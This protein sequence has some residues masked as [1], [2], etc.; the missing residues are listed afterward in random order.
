MKFLPAQ[1]T[2]ILQRGPRQRNVRLLIRFVMVLLGLMT[3]YSV[4]FHVLM[5]ME[6]QHHSW[7]S[8]FYWVLVVMSTLGFGD[9]T[10]HT[11]IGR[12]F[13][14]LVVISGL[15]FLLVLMPFT[16]IEFFYAPWMEAQAAKRAPRKLPEDTS[17]HVLITSLDPVTSV[18]MHRLTQYGH[19]YTLIVSNPEDAVRL[20][21]AGVSVMVGDPDDPET[22]RNARVDKASL[23]VATGTDVANTNIAFTTRQIS[24]KPLIVATAKEL[25]SVEIL[26]MAGANKV[27]RLDEMLGQF[28][29]RRTDG[30]PQ[31]AHVVGEFGPVLI[32]EATAGGTN[33]VG[34]T[35]KEC[36]LTER[37]RVTVVGGWDRGVFRMAS[38]DMQITSSLVLLLAGSK[39]QIDQFNQI[40]AFDRSQA[41]PVVIIGGGRVG[42]ATGVALSRMGVDFRIIEKVPDRVTDS[43]RVVLGDAADMTVLRRAGILRART[44]LITARSDEVNIYLTIY[45]RRLRPDIQIITRATL[46][47]NIATLH[48]AG[49]DFVMSYSSMGANAVF[50]LLARDNVLMVAEGLNVFKV[51][52]PPGL[53]GKRL[54]DSGIRADTGC[55]VVAFTTDTGMT[56]NPSASEILKPDGEVILIGSAES[57]ARFLAEHAARG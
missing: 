45:C 40:Y 43:E 55:N 46:E 21:D 48:R 29:A 10:F 11:D 54:A 34:K 2:H 35:L 22:Y 28:L 50:N 32:A 36:G 23:V 33:L 4:L 56:I 30:A 31:R 15:V 12:L 6:G 52:T 19:K 57:E 18:L 13:S 49:A 51:R 44:V 42:R 39:S 47:R 17:G 27:L 9:I 3:V 37:V 41:T 16:F 14:M 38:P 53:A 8:G 5:E 1:L 26:A 25:P 7:L 20:H 24:D